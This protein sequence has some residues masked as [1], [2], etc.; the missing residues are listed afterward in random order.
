MVS[1]ILTTCS[2]AIDGAHTT[3]TTKHQSTTWKGI[4]SPQIVEV[5]KRNASTQTNDSTQLNRTISLKVK[6]LTEQ[7]INIELIQNELQN[8]VNNITTGSQKRGQHSMSLRGF[9]GV[10]IFSCRGF[11]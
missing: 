4:F 8:M 5:Q 9:Y 6:T 3:T 10:G 11:A 1:I 2:T 7:G